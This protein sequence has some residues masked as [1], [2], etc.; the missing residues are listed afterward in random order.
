MRRLMITTVLL[1][2][3]LMARAGTH[4]IQ[5]QRLDDGEVGLQGGRSLGGEGSWGAFTRTKKRPARCAG[6]FA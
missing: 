5:A 4:E 1:T 2:F 6:P 3:M